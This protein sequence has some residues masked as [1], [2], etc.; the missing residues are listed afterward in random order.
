[1][2]GSIKINQYLKQSLLAYINFWLF[3]DSGVLGNATQLALN[4]RFL[5]NLTHHHMTQ[6]L[7]QI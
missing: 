3:I 6:N 5:C 2:S 4:F 7:S 1:M